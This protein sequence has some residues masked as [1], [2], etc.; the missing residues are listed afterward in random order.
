MIYLFVNKITWEGVVDY[1]MADV[2]SNNI[3]FYVGN[4][5]MRFSDAIPKIG[6][7]CGQ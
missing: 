3:N 1:N 6:D 7:W 2:S 4:P 5:K